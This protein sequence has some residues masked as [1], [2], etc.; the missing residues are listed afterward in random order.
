MTEADKMLPPPYAGKASQLDD[1]LVSA[2]ETHE[3]PAPPY[4]GMTPE[5]RMTPEGPSAPPDPPGPPGPAPPGCQPHRIFFVIIWCCAVMILAGAVPLVFARCVV[6]APAYR[7]NGIDFLTFNTEG[8]AQGKP[9]AGVSTTGAVSLCTR[10]CVQSCRKYKKSTR[11]ESICNGSPMFPDASTNCTIVE[12]M[13]AGCGDDLLSSAQA[14]TS[15]AVFFVV[16]FSVCIFLWV[17]AAIYYRKIWPP[18][19]DRRVLIAFKTM[20][21]GQY[22]LGALCAWLVWAMQQKALPLPACTT[23]TTFLG[24]PSGTTFVDLGFGAQPGEEGL[25]GAILCTISCVILLAKYW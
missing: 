23:I 14:A 17:L 20:I 1:P 15:I 11:C 2:A 10:Y 4:P 22:P 21:L 3:T 6:L 5:G 24:V 25:A 9:F 16:Q 12:P 13:T 8:L 18:I 7:G 19:Q